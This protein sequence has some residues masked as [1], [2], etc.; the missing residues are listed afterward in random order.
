MDN[1]IVHMDDRECWR[2]LETHSVARI[3]VD[4]AGR[5]DIFPINY[6]VDHGSIVFRTGAGTKFA[7]AVLG[8]YVALEI[9][10]HDGLD[11]SVWSVIVKGTAHEIDN[12]FDRFGAEEL[13]LYP[14]FVSPKPNFVRI[15]PDLVTG[16][17]FHVVNDVSLTAQTG[18]DDAYHPGE[19]RI[20]PG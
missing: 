20:R 17:R 11:R 10:G 9:D 7:A 15:H 12:M 2:L 13:P 1:A 3:A 18:I 14:W 5:P 19:P 4:V 16:R 6:V 8:R